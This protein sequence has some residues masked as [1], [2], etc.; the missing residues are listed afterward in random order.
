MIKR[1][2]LIGVILAVAMVAALCG[3]VLGM[4]VTGWVPQPAVN[5]NAWLGGAPGWLPQPDVNWNAWLGGAPGPGL[6]P[7]VNWNAW[8]GAGAQPVALVLPG[9][10]PQPSVNWNS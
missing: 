9:W 5:W 10:L 1:E 6:Q 4:A 8:L 2:K 3:M 7:N